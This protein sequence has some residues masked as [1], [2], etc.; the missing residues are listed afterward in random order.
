[1][2]FDPD[3]FLAKKKPAFDPDAFL[4]QGAEPEVQDLSAD[5]LGNMAPPDM[6]A[7]FT[8]E[9]IATTKID[10]RPKV[11][12]AAIKGVA[13]LALGVIRA[14]AAAHAVMNI[15]GN[16]GQPIEEQRAV[17]DVLIDNLYSRYYEDVIARNEMPELSADTIDTIRQGN[18]GQA[19]KELALKFIAGAPTNMAVLG[20][21]LS[22]PVAG[23]VGLAGMGVVAGG[24]KVKEAKASGVSPA[25]V[26]VDVGVT[27]A[28]ESLSELYGSF[29]IFKKWSSALSKAF[30]KKSARAVIAA[31]AKTLAASTLGEGAEEVSNSFAQD[32]TDYATGVN[33]RALEGM[34]G[35][36]AN[37]G[38]V[39]ATSG[40]LMTTPMAVMT[41]YA[42]ATEQDGGQPP[43][44]KL[45][46]NLPPTAFERAKAMAITDPIAALK[47]IAPVSEYN[48]I[49]AIGQAVASAVEA[50]ATVPAK[51][52]QA[53]S[54]QVLNSILEGSIAPVAPFAA[55]EQAPEPAKEDPGAA[56]DLETQVEVLEKAAELNGVT[57]A[58]IEAVFPDTAT[59]MRALA[60]IVKSGTAQGLTTDQMAGEMAQVLQA[61]APVTM[62]KPASEMTKEQAVDEIQALPT[63]EKATIPEAALQYEAEIADTEEPAEFQVEEEQAPEFAPVEEQ[64]TPEAAAPITAVTLEQAQAEFPGLTKEQHKGLVK[65][66]V[67]TYQ[68]GAEQVQY[69]DVKQYATEKAKTEQTADYVKG[70]LDRQMQEQGHVTPI[71]NML[72]KSKLNIAKSAEWMGGEIQADDLKGYFSKSGGMTPE[73]ATRRA[74]EAGFIAEND[75]SLFTE[76]LDAE[77]RKR[78]VMSEEGA[79]EVLTRRGAEPEVRPAYLESRE[80]YKPEDKID[81]L[82]FKAWFGDS[83]VVDDKG[84][85]LV[86]YHQTAEDRGVKI[87]GEGFKTSEE[88]AKSRLSDHQVPNGIFF[89]PSIKD[90]GVGGG[91]G[92]VQIPVYLSIKNPLIVEDRYE[93]SKKIQALDPKYINYEIKMHEV[94]TEYSQKFNKEWEL[95]ERE[96]KVERLDKITAEWKAEENKTAAEARSVID[97]V[98]ADNGYDGV[99]INID[100][101][102]WNRKT[103]TFIALNSVQVKSPQ[104]RGTYD[105][106][107]PNIL[108]APGHVYAP[109]ELLKNESDALLPGAVKQAVADTRKV[110]P[111]GQWHDLRKDPAIGR[112]NKA[113]MEKGF[114]S[115]IGQKIETIQDV[116]EIAAFVRHPRIEHLAVIKVID[117]KIAGSLVLTSGKIGYIDPDMAEIKKFTEDADEFYMTHNHP[118]GDATPS[119]ADIETTKEMAADKRF[120]GHVVTDHQTYTRIDPDGKA[121]A[122]AFKTEQKPFRT[123][124]EEMS[125]LG[126]AQWARGT[127]QGENLGIMFVDSNLHVMSFDQVDPTSD[128]NAYIKAHSTKYG[129]V[130]VFLVAGE[131]AYKKMEPRK[132]SGNYYDVIVLSDNGDYKSA[133]LGNIKGFSL[134]KFN[135]DT[136]EE[137]RFEAAPF[138][139]TPAKYNP[140]EYKGKAGKLKPGKALTL[141]GRYTDALF[142]KGL[143]RGTTAKLLQSSPTTGRLLVEIGGKQVIMTPDMFAETYQKPEPMKVIP[144]KPIKSTIERVTGVK[145]VN[146]EVITTQMKLLKMNMASAQR[147]ARQAAKVT[148]AAILEDIRVKRG[149]EK[150]VRAAVSAYVKENLPPDQRGRFL[151]LVEKAVTTTDLAKAVLKVDNANADAYRKAIIDDIKKVANRALE[152]QRVDVE[153]REA[154]KELLANIDFVKRRPETILRLK[155]MREYINRMEDSG[156]AEFIPDHIFK[157]LEILTLRPVAAISEEELNIVLRD[158]LIIES[159]GKDAQATKELA[160]GIDKGVWLRSLTEKQ[161]RH[162]NLAED[163]GKIQKTWAKAQEI[164][165]ALAPMVIV[166]DRLDGGK[167]TYDGAHVQLYQALNGDY[168]KYLDLKR[169]LIQPVLD[170]I[171]KHGLNEKSMNQIGIYA[172]KVQVNGPARVLASMPDMTEQEVTD[173]KL[174]AQEMEVYTA[175]RAAMEA[176]Y[177]ATKRLMG[178]LYN[179]SMGS[180]DNYFSFQTDWDKLSEMEVMERLSRTADEFTGTRKNI[181]AGFTKERVKGAQVPI[182]TNALNVFLKHI[183]DAAYFVAMQE[184]VKKFQEI[185]SMEGY[186]EAVGPQGHR[187]IKSWLDLLARQGRA[188]GSKKIPALDWLRKNV[189]ASIMGFKLSTFL[190][191]NSSFLDAAALTG[192]ANVI[193]GAAIVASDQAA[194]DWLMMSLPKLRERAGNDLSFS[195]LSENKMMEYIQKK[196][197]VPLQWMD[198]KV[199]A[200]A[201]MSA[202]LKR[203]KEMG[204]SVDYGKPMPDDVASYANY[205]LSK[206]QASPFFID[207]GVAFNSSK[208]I[209]L[210]NNVSVNKSILQFKQFTINRWFFMS[211]DVP[212]L[213]TGAD[214]FQAA[215]YLATAT[216][217]EMGIRGASNG[218]TLAMLGAFG[219]GIAAAVRGARDDDEMWKDYVLQILSQVPYLDMPL[220]AIR[221]GSIPIPVIGKVA[222]LV[223]NA[224]VASG[225]QSEYRQAVALRKSLVALATLAGIPGTAQ[226]GQIWAWSYNPKSLTFPYNAEYGKLQ[227]IGGARTYGEEARFSELESSKRQFSRYAKIYRDAME[228]DDIPAATMAAQGAAHALESL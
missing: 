48:R 174:T 172:L 1:M 117:G 97:K 112:I 56:P 140:E 162:I 146:Q 65:N 81:T 169:N 44:V 84:A 116:A 118:T 74:F 59:G 3:A 200:T 52:K 28:A 196:G 61:Q 2:A 188:E 24:Q 111:V 91:E 105:P 43:T 190:I 145:P 183:N 120:K 173:L 207:T 40:G 85:P 198:K 71:L 67:D 137:N 50:D 155:A 215:A 185:T 164:Y 63:E 186:A 180:V 213:K 179:K 225:A 9:Q 149:G 205:V 150:E 209:L 197:Y 53:I 57:G 76:A 42:R 38:L 39:G 16:I 23:A 106:K 181:S 135:E 14:P 113:L 30:G 25:M 206:T 178:K 194:L 18:Y 154:A 73:Q 130:A 131:G 175:M 94:E 177:P 122:E 51:Q 114:A 22:G 103:K 201:V 193:Q 182:Q 217:A 221:Y 60:D 35:R 128:Y 64:A 139:E 189:G 15:G 92:H 98:L 37:A 33:P 96:D 153:Y 21:A 99:I 101:G 49:D 115:A 34:A 89:K 212:R 125:T 157:R 227:D 159:V 223:L 124:T 31:T 141:R 104:N 100:N 220:S 54:A 208:S 158:L 46:P 211:Y 171:E 83:K 204:I 147:A 70:E 129:S 72:G 87:Y 69:E 79:D 27:G 5:D 20:A 82:A 132:L 199:A 191:Q 75:E 108:H 134:P 95:K 55:T 80:I 143:P 78:R 165:W 138:R 62:S 68:I 77:I 8:P 41:G 176:L 156:R 47:S 32:I 109:N 93:L 148:K 136:W 163:A 107:D 222:D 102:S 66:A 127:L 187:V 17:P 170:L 160:E 152:S 110:A 228:K 4:A 192:G 90:I 12:K 58:D 210:I 13:G 29:G 119:E 166:M 142:P 86:V 203:S 121:T 184:N 144:G 6:G 26:G 10:E 133:Q 219:M 202:V 167:G 218:I 151:A 123:D 11:A 195:E 216:M 88:L 224:R 7:E 168:F 36:A 226:A 161:I 214:K 19:G 126:V 45:S